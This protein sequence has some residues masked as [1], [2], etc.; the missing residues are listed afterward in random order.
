MVVMLDT[1]CSEVQCKITGYPLHSHVS[2]SLP[3]PCVTVSHQVSTELYIYFNVFQKVAYFTHFLITCFSWLESSIGPGT[4]HYQASLSNSDTHHTLWNSSGRMIGPPLRLLPNNTQ[5]TKATDNH[6]PDGIL[7]RNLNMRAAAGPR[8][9]SP[10]YWNRQQLT[11]CW[12][13]CMNP[14]FLY[15]RDRCSSVYKTYKSIIRIYLL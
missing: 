12:K 7:N 3:L 2:P 5:H 9:R 1:P 10:G 6:N 15:I 4:F 8:H 11:Y 13:F 14:F